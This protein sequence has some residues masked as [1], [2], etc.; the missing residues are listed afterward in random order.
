MAGRIIA[1]ILQLSLGELLQ[2]EVAFLVDGSQTT[3]TSPSNHVY[4]SIED[5][6]QRWKP[7]EG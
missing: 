4:Y 2:L 6:N 7:Q 3:G 1:L 5:F